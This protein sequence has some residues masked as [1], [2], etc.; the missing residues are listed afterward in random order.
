MSSIPIDFKI[1][2]K[3]IS[4]MKIKTQLWDTAGQ[5]R[6]RTLTSAYYRGA[7]GLIICYDITDRRSFE[8]IQ[9]NWLKQAERHAP[10]DTYARTVI[11]GLKTDLA[12]ERAV[13]YE[14]GLEFATLNGFSFYEV[15]SKT[16]DGAHNFYT[17]YVTY[18]VTG[19]APCLG[20]PAH[21]PDEKRLCKVSRRKSWFPLFSKSVY[22][23]GVRLY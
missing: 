16:G 13:S 7:H 18:I 15:T 22:S 21:L 9:N 2:T 12:A 17:Q 4:G 23:I 5:E 8:S 3:E 19:A 10:E 1:I 14:E 11:V 20:N 6:F